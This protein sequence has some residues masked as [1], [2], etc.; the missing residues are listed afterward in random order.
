MRIGELAER[1]G[2]STSRVRFYEARGLLPFAAR[3]ANG[4][5]DYGDHALDVLVFIGR[6]QSL[7]FTWREVAAH[8]RSRAGKGRKTRLRA[9]LESKLSELDAQAEAML[10][11]RA[12]IV[13]LIEELR[14]ISP[15]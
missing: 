15:A 6:A 14:N 9:R 10:A 7:G 11:R 8:L 1:A 4:Y 12:I 5:R 3:L 2:V 13:D